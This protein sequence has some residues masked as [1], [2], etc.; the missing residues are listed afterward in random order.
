MPVPRSRETPTWLPIGR[1]R[2]GKTAAGSGASSM[3]A[4]VAAARGRACPCEGR[5]LACA[6]PGRQRHRPLY[7]R[8]A[9]EVLG[10]TGRYQRQEGHHDQPGHLS[11]LS[12]RQ[13]QPDLRGRGAEP[14][15]GLRL[16]I[17]LVPG[18]G[19]GQALA[20]NRVC[21]L[22]DRCLRQED[23]WMAGVHLDDHGLRPGRAE[24]GHMP[25]SAVR[26]GRSDPPFRQRQPV[27]IHQVHRTPGGGRDRPI[28]RQRRRQL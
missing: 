26:S 7:R 20:G 1:S 6:A 16:H 25:E 10:I 5:G 11:A 9:D 12:R 24:P 19:P 27:R 23:C 14:A 28:R 4:A 2:T 3:P 13:G 18:S 15:L 8:A 17:C 22:R 21:R